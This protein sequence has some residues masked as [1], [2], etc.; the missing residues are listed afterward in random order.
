MKTSSL[1]A[2][3]VAVY[4]A[5][6]ALPVARAAS[7]ET[8][9]F[10]FGST[11]TWQHPV[12]GQDPE[13]TQPG[14]Q[15]N[16]MKASW[17][18]LP[19]SGVG[20]FGYGV[21]DFEAI[22]TSIGTPASGSRYTAYFKRQFTLSNAMSG[23]FFVNMLCDD[24]AVIYLDGVRVGV[25]NY[26]GSDTYSA[27]ATTSGPEDHDQWVKLTPTTLSAGAHTIAVSLHN[28]AATS[29]DLAFDLRLIHAT[30]SLN[31][32]VF[33]PVTGF[34]YQ[35]IWVND[36]VPPSWTQAKAIA[37]TAGGRLPV[38]DT[39]AKANALLSLL[40]SDR[41][42][43]RVRHAGSNSTIFSGPHAG[44][45]QLPDS[46]EPDGGWVWLDGTVV[47]PSSWRAGSPVS[48]P[49]GL[50]NYSAYSGLNAK[51]AELGATDI[52]SPA[53]HRAVLVEL[54]ASLTITGVSP[55]PVIGLNG[56]QQFVITGS[57]FASACTV[58]LR[59]L[60]NGSVYPNRTKSAQSATSITLNPNFGN[61]AT[62]WSV[63]VINAGGVSSGQFPFPVNA[64]AVVPTVTPGVAP[65]TQTGT[66]TLTLLGN[67]TAG[68]I[69]RFFSLDTG[70][71]MSTPATI[72]PD[73][74]A[75]V[76][77][78]F[79]DT[80][81][82][83]ATV[84]AAN[85]QTAQPI[86]VSVISS[87]LELSF[88]LKDSG[89]TAYTHPVNSIFDHAMTD[90]YTPGIGA[91]LGVQAF[92]GEHATEE[93]LL[94]GP[95]SPLSSFRKHDKSVLLS[96]VINYQG[97]TRAY[98]D[99]HNGYDYHAVMG[100]PVYAAAPGKIVGVKTGWRTTLA[101]GP[102]G[103]FVRIQHGT[104]GYQTAYLHLNSVED[105]IKSGVDVYEGQLLGTVG[106]TGNSVGAHLHFTVNKFVGKTYISVDPYGWIGSGPDSYKPANTL[107]WRAQELPRPRL[108]MSE[109]QITAAGTS[110]A[111]S[112][113][114][115]AGPQNYSAAV[116]N[117]DEWISIT[118]G[119][120]GTGSSTLSFAVAA[121]AGAARSGEIAI[122]IPVGGTLKVVV[123]QSGSGNP[124]PAEIVV[125]MKLMA[126]KFQIPTVLI[127]AIAHKES[128]WRQFDTGGAPLVGVS[129]DIGLMQINIS[130]PAPGMD[131]VRVGSDWIYNLEIGCRILKEAKW[132]AKTRKP[133]G[134]WG[135]E[136]DLDPAI[137]ENWFY[138]VAWYNGQGTAAYAYISAIW[139]YLKSPPS[140]ISDYFADI[141]ALG[142]PRDLFGFPATIHT[143]F[144]LPNV[145][146]AE[147]G[148]FVA[149]G[150]Y[151]LSLL[152]L[153]D[154]TI[155]YWNWDNNSTGV[156][157][158]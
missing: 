19:N 41:Y 88:P 44:A 34:R 146:S 130:S 53:S 62:A 112:T 126:K 84:Q 106:S 4:C 1:F 10:P 67:F 70:V 114:I 32:S 107:L 93:P 99:G 82:W 61:S 60:S 64:P 52:V 156:T 139:G 136:K 145:A 21:F 38:A 147:P 42:W 18:N 66:Q 149:S 121:N 7:D 33:L 23:E 120:T 51:K 65:V 69:V 131:I 8:Q 74:S 71:A 129:G 152:K 157:A 17:G 98:Y 80:G 110:G 81:K 43:N 28:I 103:N 68:S 96:G 158:A 46:V 118:N 73:G 119:V 155:H 85:G 135:S 5:F 87:S 25:V 94:L 109:F 48:D 22:A 37:E 86:P 117:G 116:R 63:E 56:Q 11:W 141:P 77:Q 100:T 79:A 95:T 24:G 113:V 14:F 72:N 55:S 101:D 58:T 40:D 154:A 30:G 20:I 128:Q 132:G 47:S 78:T 148:P 153:N 49:T 75:T 102:N 6:F 111:Q 91:T 140:P 13:A 123:K 9:I 143:R 151:T 45:Y 124:T 59:N 54:P 50:F 122:H 97:E 29:S 125:Q 137:I 115:H 39:S 142:D 104:T 138:P 35:M 76:T 89:M 2:L 83:A 26:S 134:P 15:A 57:S 92:N 12:N 133:L 127:A 150:L 27:I 144:D 31:Q 3:L 16:W 105:G 108:D 36:L 90:I